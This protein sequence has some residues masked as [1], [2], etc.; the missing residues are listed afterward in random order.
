MLE[1]IKIQKIKDEGK[2]LGKN[3]N[4]DLDLE[5]VSKRDNRVLD[6]NK[7]NIDY[8]IELESDV[9][10]LLNLEIRADLIVESLITPDNFYVEDT[11]DLS[12]FSLELLII[13]LPIK[14]FLDS[15]KDLFQD[16][17]EIIQPTNKALEK[18]KDL[19]D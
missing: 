4:V 1:K 9:Q 3:I 7:V 2:Y 16:E 8:H 12:D 14:L 5:T 13:E 18:I 10:L 15:E 11:V 6:I 17:N 19:F